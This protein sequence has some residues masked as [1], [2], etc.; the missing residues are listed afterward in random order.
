MPGRLLPLAL[1]LACLAPTGCDTPPSAEDPTPKPPR[2]WIDYGG[3]R[4]GQRYTTLA[5]ITPENVDRLEVAWTH[6]S[7]DVSDGRSLPSTSA[8]ELTP[9]LV[10]GTLYA[11]RLN[12]STTSPSSRSA[13]ACRTRR[14]R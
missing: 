13:R 8:Y 1:A 4:G 12:H 6:H 7:G 5:D 10:D 14:Q 11:Q 9:I 2:D 3:D